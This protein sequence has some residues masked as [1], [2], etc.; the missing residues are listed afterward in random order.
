MDAAFPQDERIVQP[1]LRAAI[2]RGLTSACLPLS[3]ILTEKLRRDGVNAT[4]V[5]GLHLSANGFANAHYW[6]DVVLANGMV[7]TIDPGL[8]VTCRVNRIPAFTFFGANVPTLECPSTHARIDL[9]TDDEMAECRRCQILYN[10][11]V[12]NGWDGFLHCLHNHKG[13]GPV[14]ILLDI[15][16]AEP[17]PLPC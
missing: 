17:R 15:A 1:V 9:D 14:T 13:Q 4:V 12:R 11:F 3:I 8:Y 2:A 10:I 5:Q 6:I 7:M 16:R